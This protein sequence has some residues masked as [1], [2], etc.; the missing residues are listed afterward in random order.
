MLTLFNLNIKILTI[1]SLEKD[2]YKLLYLG[3]SQSAKNGKISEKRTKIVPLL[4]SVFG[5]EAKC[6]EKKI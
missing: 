2:F 6:D 3:T 4:N 1:R 5:V